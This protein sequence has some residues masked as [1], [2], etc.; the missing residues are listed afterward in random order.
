MIGA[1]SPMS[2][3]FWLGAA[4]LGFLTLGNIRHLDPALETRP[5]RG[6]S[7][8]PRGGARATFTV[9]DGGRP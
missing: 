3:P 5:P 2:A 7:R 6:W 8:Q 4:K 1:L 9:H